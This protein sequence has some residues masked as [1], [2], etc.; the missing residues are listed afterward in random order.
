M[1]LFIKKMQD[2]IDENNQKIPEICIRDFATAYQKYVSGKIESINWSEIKE[3]SEDK[4]IKYQNLLANQQQDLCEIAV[5]HLDQLVVLKLN[6][7]LG[8]SMGLKYAKSKIMFD[9]K[10]EKTFLDII[11][12][13]IVEI[14]E[15]YQKNVDLWFFN[16]FNTQKDT[17]AFFYQKKI[18]NLVY[19]EI[20]QNKFP[21]IET[22]LIDNEINYLPFSYSENYEQEW[23]PPGH[24]DIYRVFHINKIIE[25]WLKQGKKFLFVSNSDNLGANIDLMIFGYFLK[26]N[27]PFLMEVCQKTPLDRKGGIIVEYQNEI[28]LVESVEVPKKNITDFEN[29]NKYCFFNT[30]SLWFYLPAL[31]EILKNKFEIPLIINPKTINKRDVIQLESAMGSIIRF[32]PS[33]KIIKVPRERFL[34][35]KTNNELLLMRSDYLKDHKINL[36]RKKVDLVPEIKLSNNY[37]DLIDFEKYFQVIPSLI[38]IE[39]LYLEGEIFFLNSGNI[40]LTGEVIIKSLDLPLEIYGDVKL[41]NTEIVLTNDHIKINYLDQAELQLNWYIEKKNNKYVLKSFNEF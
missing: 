25:S 32:F 34:A 5:Q 24:G 15:K 8:T 31:L 4:V 29:I 35:V 41:E 30:N 39:K 14:N 7:G 26:E 1:D 19:H 36:L 3:I 12:D 23:Y 38:N 16:S 22:Q 40:E 33:S 9:V 11:I 27:L 20:I 17:R 21:R 28:R 37:H 6:G 10:N 13:Q 18:K 2:H